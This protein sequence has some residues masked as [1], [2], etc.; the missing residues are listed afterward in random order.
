MSA[1]R[2]FI[3]VLLL[4]LSFPSRASTP[5][6]SLAGPA[7]VLIGGID[8]SA[9]SPLSTSIVGKSKPF[10][11]KQKRVI[12]Q[13]NADTHGGRN[14]CEECG[15]ETVEPKKHEKGV[16]PPLNETHVDHKIP[17]AKGGPSE[18]DNGQV[19]CRDCNIKK[20]DKLPPQKKSD[21]L[22]PQEEQP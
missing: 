17:Q 16:S 22:P 6:S 2:M 21:K 5:G 4:V 3:A 9:G 14:Q 8:T 20:S 11:R 18:I 12:K 1:F 10:T 19:L 15:T 13:E 7:P